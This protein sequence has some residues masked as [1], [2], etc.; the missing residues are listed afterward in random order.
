MDVFTDEILLPF[1]M[2]SSCHKLIEM[3]VKRS[4]GNW[5]AERSEKKRKRGG[6]VWKRHGEKTKKSE[7]CF[8]MK[9]FVQSS[10]LPVMWRH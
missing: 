10:S 6:K 7:T 2:F 8:Y 4:S 1:I 5:I 9:N 3:V